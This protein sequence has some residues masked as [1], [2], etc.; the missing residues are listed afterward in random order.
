MM[1]G[2]L[3]SHPLP[4][5]LS[6]LRAR[7]ASGVLTLEKKPVKR[8]IC[9]LKGFIRLAVSNVREER[10][11]EFLVRNRILP[12]EVVHGAEVQA[13][14]GGPKL[15]EAL[16][17]SG[18]I[19]SGEMQRHV[20]RH[21]LEI[22]VACF[23]LEDAEYRFADGL[24]N[25]VG[26][27]MTDIPPL[28]ALLER[29]RQRPSAPVHQRIQ[30]TPNLVVLM[31]AA[32]EADLQRMK[33]NGAESYI[34]SRAGGANALGA[35]LR[36]SP[37]EETE[38][39]G[40]ASAL[41]ASGIVTLAAGSQERT[42]RRTAEHSAMATTGAGAA[43]VNPSAQS[44]IASLPYYDRMHALLMGADHYK[45]LDVPPGA[46]ADQVREAYY[47]LAKEIHPDRFLSPPFD[48]LHDKMEELFSQVL[49]AYRTLTDPAARER[50]DA[51]RTT[52]G[53]APKPTLSESQELA[54]QNYLR[55]R[56]LME[57][58]KM[59]EAVRFLQ[60]AVDVEPNRADYRR[61]LAGAQAGN[62]RMRREAIEN[63]LKAIDL[64][65]A[66]SDTYLQVGLLYRRL[67][68]TTKAEA[69]LRECIKWDPMNTEAIR[70]L[71]EM[72]GASK[73]VSG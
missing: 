67:G 13:A 53:Q 50:Y 54:R 51:E 71:E 62:P 6:T 27:I 11:G 58:G 47:R 7:G 68:E 72:K 30:S 18:V 8:Q 10:L 46:A 37:F 29:C 4:E 21:I 2:R 5:L 64:D 41:A 23:D 63:Y 65:P 15:A 45:T 17:V 38:T 48:V 43:P 69:T 16:I 9:I 40:A 33:L 34:V 31:N 28:E 14:T 39:L 60:N 1:K 52:T 59:T 66:L 36:D 20:R 57:M 25:I 22:L 55:G 49:E 42:S 26:E 73:P 12:D 61:V 35:I 24:P 56:A 70:A 44:S 32:L 3:K 19:S